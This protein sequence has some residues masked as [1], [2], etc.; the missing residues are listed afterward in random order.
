MTWIL[1]SCLAQYSFSGWRPSLK[2]WELEEQSNSAPKT[3]F[4]NVIPE[5]LHLPNGLHPISPRILHHLW[6]INLMQL[7][8][9]LISSNLTKRRD[10]W[11]L[12]MHI[13]WKSIKSILL[14]STWMNSENSSILTLVMNHY[15]SN[16]VSSKKEMKKI[17]LKAILSSNTLG[18]WIWTQI[19]MEFTCKNLSK[20]SLWVLNLGILRSR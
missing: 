4:L 11:R 3:P 14:N 5:K 15:I 8:T 6:N 12:S 16:G 17:F 13:S 9:M 19:L 20:I 2:A 1:N 10:I 18:S 7:I